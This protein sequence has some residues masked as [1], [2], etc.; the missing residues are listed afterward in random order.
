MQRF[1]NRC[2]ALVAPSESM[3]EVLRA[4][5]MNEDIGIWSRGVDRTIFDPDRRDLAWRRAL[6]IDDDD[7]AIGFLSCCHGKGSSTVFSERSPRCA[8]AGSR[9]KVLV[10]RRRSCAGL[11]RR[12]GSGSGIHRDPYRSD[13]GRVVASMDLLLNPS[14]RRRSATSRSRRGLW[15]PCQL[16]RERPAARAWWSPANRRWSSRARL[17]DFA[18]ALAAYASD[19]RYCAV[20]TALAGE[21]RSRAYSWDAIIASWPKR[22]CA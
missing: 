17:P 5:G 4:Q 21:V 8:N 19:P 22:T 2:D 18:D 10:R 14:G 9:H 12:A 15:L 1:Y 7:V 13:L 16:P 11:V 3:A 6:G 20:P